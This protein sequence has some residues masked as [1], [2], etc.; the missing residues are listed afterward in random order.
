M[1]VNQRFETKETG[2][3][4]DIAVSLLAKLLH[5]QEI[6]AETLLAA[7]D[8]VDMGHSMGVWCGDIIDYVVKPLI[9][10]PNISLDFR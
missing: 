8:Q 10:S 5:Q 2:A 3:E 4:K 9:F 1:Y 6:D 7:K